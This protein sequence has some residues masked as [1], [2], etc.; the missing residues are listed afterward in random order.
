MRAPDLQP[1]L[2]SKIDHLGLGTCLSQERF[3]EYGQEIRIGIRAWFG[4]FV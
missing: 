1:P 4:F 3:Y 2:S